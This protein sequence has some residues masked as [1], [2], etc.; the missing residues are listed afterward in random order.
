MPGPG[1]FF[2][3]DKRSKLILFKRIFTTLNVPSLECYLF[4]IQANFR[5]LI[6]ATRAW[7]TSVIRWMILEVNACV[8]LARYAKAESLALEW[9]TVFEAA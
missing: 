6:V 9:T 1:T 7:N 2:R 4:S 5:A 8:E 3:F